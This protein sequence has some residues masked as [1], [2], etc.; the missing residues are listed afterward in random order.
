[1]KLGDVRIAHTSSNNQDNDEA[2]VAEFDEKGVLVSWPRTLGFIDAFFLNVNK[3]KIPDPLVLRDEKGWL[4]LTNGITVGTSASTLGHSLERIRYERAI[5]AGA[6]GVDYGEID[7]M[8]SEIEGLAKW[9]S[10]TPVETKLSFNQE[11]NGVESVEITAR[12]IDPLPL[13]GPLSLELITSY[14]HKPVPENGVYSISTALRVRTRSSQSEHWQTHQQT[15][16]MMQDLMCLVYGK[17]CDAQLI[18]V[19]REDDQDQIRSDGRRF[20]RDAYE[21]AFGRSGDSEA[22]LSEKAEPLF[23][24]ADTD[25]AQVSQWLLDY[26]YWSRPTWIAIS[27]IYYPNVPVESL[28]LQV[29]VALEALGYA[30]AK[31]AAPEQKPKLHFVGYLMVIFDFLGYEPPAV[32]GKNGDRESWCKSFNAAYKGVKHADKDLTESREAWRRMREGLNLFRCWLASAL[33]VPNEVI[34]NV[35]LSGNWDPELHHS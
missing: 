33:G 10:R 26:S 20:W 5:H 3:H 29:A 8:T 14:S 6:K 31:K 18:S 21:P 30:I 19:M 32:V 9:A 15:H 1:M 7:G 16:R 17:P 35:R 27:A 11:S 12:N 23:Y 28:L 25:K 4:T 22:Q 24:L 13:G 34:L 2:V